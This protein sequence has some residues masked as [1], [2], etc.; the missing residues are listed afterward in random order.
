MVLPI[1]PYFLISA[2]GVFS[3]LYVRAFGVNVVVRDQW[4]VATLFGELFSG[5]LSLADL[6]APHNEH[7]FFFPG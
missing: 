5:T 1:L 7:R 6:W 2:P 4:E 3:L